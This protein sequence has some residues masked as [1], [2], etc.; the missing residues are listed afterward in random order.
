MS[1]LV[2]KDKLLI[3][4]Q[5]YNYHKH[6]QITD[7]QVLDN[8]IQVSIE[9]LMLQYPKRNINRLDRRQE[10][11]FQY[12]SINSLED[13]QDNQ[14]LFLLLFLAYKYRLGMGFQQLSMY[15]HNNCPICTCKHLDFKNIRS[16]FQ[17]L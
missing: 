4:L 10:L 14:K 3:L 8:S 2:L 12:L 13:K 16:S 11:L 6:R 1:Q 17:V 7:Q 9:V 15:Y 5:L